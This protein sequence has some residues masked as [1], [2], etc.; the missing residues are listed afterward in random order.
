MF[1]SITGLLDV[2]PFI[3]GRCLGQLGP[4]EENLGWV[5]IPMAFSLKTK[6]FLKFSLYKEEP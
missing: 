4:I 2:C 3:L 6:A 1:I 5:V